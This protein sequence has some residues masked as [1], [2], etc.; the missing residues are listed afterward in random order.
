V[1]LPRLEEI[2]FQTDA[3]N[4]DFAKLA[5]VYEA[6]LARI[7]QQKIVLVPTLDKIITW[8]EGYAVTDARK[9]LC[10]QYA[11]T[12]VRRFYQMGGTIALGDDSGFETRTGMPVAEMRRL[13]SV[14]MTSLQVIQASTQTAA[15]VCGHS[16]ELGTL[17][18]GKHAG[19]IV[20]KGNP[21]NDIEAMNWISIVI[22]D[23]QV[24]VPFK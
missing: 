22:V 13:L 23:G 6:Q 9:R 8:C 16:D 15:R 20:V 19:V 1:P 3:S 11:L 18:P 4:R 7:V 24:A 5:P 2:E 17:E 12:P 21:L 10:R 14:G